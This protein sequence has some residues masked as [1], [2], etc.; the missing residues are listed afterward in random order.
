MQKPEQMKLTTEHQRS[1]AQKEH[2]ETVIK[3][4]ITQAII[5]TTFKINLYYNC[6][7]F[8][9]FIYFC[10]RNLYFFDFGHL[11]SCIHFNR[12]HFIP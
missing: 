4:N 6:S 2:T 7:E 10:A 9:L 3:I 5:F 11:K 1:R 8:N 12:R